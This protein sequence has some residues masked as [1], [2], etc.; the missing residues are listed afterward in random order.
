MDPHEVT[1]EQ[2]EKFVKATGYVTVAE[3][4]PDPADF[5]NVPKE[6]LVPFSGVFMPPARC[7]PEDCKH[8]DQ[9]WK[10]VDGASWRQP[11]GPGSD[12]KGKEKHPV[13]HVAWDD[14]LAYCKWAGKRLP[15]EAEWEYAA[16]GG[17]EGKRYYWGDELKPGGKWMA[18]IWQGAFPCENTL[19]DGHRGT[20]PVGSYPPNAFGL[21][22]MC[23]NVWEWTS[24]W[25]LPG[26]EARPDQLRI[27][28]KGPDYSFDTHGRN[29]LKRVVRGGSFLCSDYYCKRYRA[30]GRMQSEL[31]TGL[32]HTGFRCV[33]SKS[34][35][36]TRK[37]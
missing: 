33:W 5:P 17:L 21:Y 27:N 19:E 35:A 26:F 22:D 1:N 9:W 3:Q 29:E 37:K 11:R 31:K 25:Y 18:N 20:A 28:P 4:Q 32:E 12:I 10:P 2:F 13:V 6:K 23:G 15:T 16:R 24:D 36:R 7:K 30:G 8:C 14:V 34:E